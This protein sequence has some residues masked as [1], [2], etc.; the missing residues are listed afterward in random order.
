M[1]LLATAPQLMSLDWSAIGMPSKRVNARG[2]FAGL[3]VG[4]I[5]GYLYFS[6]WLRSF[7]HPHFIKPWQK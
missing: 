2:A 1:H 7:H 4:F 6:F 3:L 5:V